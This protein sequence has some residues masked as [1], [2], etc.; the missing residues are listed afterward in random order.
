MYLGSWDVPGIVNRTSAINFA[1]GVSRKDHTNIG[2][3]IVQ[4]FS[5][6]FNNM[7]QMCMNKHTQGTID[8]I[9]I[10]T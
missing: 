9:S 2:E 4:L 3:L 5:T 1:L 7:F 8:Q 10:K 6:I